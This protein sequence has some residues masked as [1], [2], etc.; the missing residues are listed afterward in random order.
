MDTNCSHRFAPLFVQG[1][2]HTGAYQEKRKKLARTFSFTFLYLDDGLSLNNS[3]LSDFNGRI[4]RIELEIQDNTDKTRYASYLDLHLE[5][6]SEDR[7]R[8]KLYDKRDD[9]TF[10]IVNFH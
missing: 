6:D 2:P 7:L 10:Q 1:I 9:F 3:K 5:I 4:H 8:T